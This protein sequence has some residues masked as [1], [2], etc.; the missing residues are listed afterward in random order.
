M[1][2]SSFAVLGLMVFSS[3][4][5]TACLMTRDEIADEE[6]RKAVQQQVSTLQK[7]SADE[8]SHY[9]EVTDDMRDLRGKVEVLDNRQ[10]QQAKDLIAAQATQNQQLAETNKHITALQEE[11]QKL[12]NQVAYLTQEVVKLESAKPAPVAA[13]ATPASGKADK[14]EAFKAAEENFGKKN[15]KQAILDYQ[16]Y[17][18]SFPNGKK[19]PQATYKIGLAFKELG[20]KDEAR[21]FFEEV[22]TKFPDNPL[23]KLAKDQL[24]AK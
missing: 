14:G 7:T 15:Y 8:Q 3:L 11:M 23:A 20:M 17:R 22:Q 21:S 2:S 9:S 16:K 19:F 13:A 18:D 10:N 12:S 6:Q 4:S 24:K 5:L 1:K